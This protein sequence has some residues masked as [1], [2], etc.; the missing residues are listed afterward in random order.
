MPMVAFGTS[1]DFPGSTPARIQPSLPRPF[2][3]CNA[4]QH[5]STKFYVIRRR[6]GVAISC[7]CGTQ[8]ET[9]VGAV[10]FWKQPSKVPKMTTLKLS[11]I[12]PR[13]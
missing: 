10:E 2:K 1:A 9:T 12:N 8:F 13:K 7:W 5:R 6:G 11:L 4:A 3:V